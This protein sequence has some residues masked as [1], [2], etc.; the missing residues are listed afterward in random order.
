MAECAMALHYQAFD[1]LDPNAPPDPQALANALTAWE[2]LAQYTNP[3]L[4]SMEVTSPDGETGIQI[5]LI[6][7]SDS[8]ALPP[9]A[10]QPLRLVA[11]PPVTDA[12]VTDLP[13]PPSGDDGG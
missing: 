12:Q 3:K 8:A 2:K 10:D 11:E 9:S 13:S 6:N 1:P 5:N 4:K 7:Y